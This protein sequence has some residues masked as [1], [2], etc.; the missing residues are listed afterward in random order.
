M[1]LPVVTNTHRLAFFF[2]FD[3]T[4]A[5]IAERP[6]DV[7]VT[8]A[9]RD[10]LNALRELSGGA[11]AIVTGR[12][13]ASIDHFLAPLRL[14][15]A[16][17]HGLTRRDANG[18]VHS[19]EIDA[20]ALDAIAGRLAALVEREDGLLIE[21]K[22]GGLALHYRRRPELEDVC[23]T[24]MEAAS[25]DSANISL[26]RGKMVIEAVAHSSNK[27][28][29]IESFLAE[30]PFRGRIPVFAGDDVTDEDGFAFVNA[31]GGV[32]IK[33]GAG[34]TIARHRSGDREELL[35]WL[36]RVIDQARKT[37]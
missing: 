26:R 20:A 16:G 35:A 24:A 11:V 19:P 6:E 33:I 10:A 15:V 36:S 31:Q 18:Q 4:L 34:S 29:A 7:E 28:A 8:D 37:Q 23:I 17:V 30:E 21:R 12:D 14:P 2:D 13:I 5:D 27:G 32:S 25:A 1:P 22:H 9:T 3:G